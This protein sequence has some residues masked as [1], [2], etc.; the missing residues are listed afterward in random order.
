VLISISTAFLFEVI[1]KIKKTIAS[2][3]ILMCRLNFKTGIIFQFSLPVPV[4]DFFF[5]FLRNPVFIGGV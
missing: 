5:H 3:I 1:I 2:R 4:S